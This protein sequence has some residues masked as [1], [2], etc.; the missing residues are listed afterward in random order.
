M[1]LR[2]TRTLHIL[3]RLGMVLSLILIFID[4][5]RDQLHLVE[6]V[7]FFLFIL[8]AYLDYNLWRCPHCGYHLRK[9]IPFPSSCPHCKCSIYLDD[10]V[11]V[12][13]AKR[14]Q[15]ETMDK[16]KRSGS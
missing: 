14:R 8:A 9:M 12:E 5:N 15:K 3:A 7:L 13:E 16:E 10:R 6:P 2:T 11:H 4:K 1:K